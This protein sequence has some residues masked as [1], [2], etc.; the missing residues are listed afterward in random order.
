MSQTAITYPA[1]TLNEMSGA[2]IREILEDIADNRFNVD[3][4]YQQGGDMVRVGGL[5][6]SIDP[7]VP[8]GKRISDME[9]GGKNAGQQKIQGGRLGSVNKNAQGK[10]IWDVVSDHLQTMKHVKVKHMNIPKIKNVK[11]NHGIA[12]ELN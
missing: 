10:P 5:D 8:K 4:Y 6:Y 2:T 12:D 3:P 11:G 9:V 7:T 1:T